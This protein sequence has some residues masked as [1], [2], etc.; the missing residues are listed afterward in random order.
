MQ[1]LIESVE[2]SMP[3]VCQA[4]GRSH[5]DDQ[6]FLSDILV[7]W[8]ERDLHVH[9]CLFLEMTMKSRIQK[10]KG[11]EQQKEKKKSDKKVN[12]DAHGRKNRHVRDERRPTQ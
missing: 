9:V 4:R 10:I 6:S 8:R 2:I 11:H 12:H 7:S 3:C 5:R 1:I